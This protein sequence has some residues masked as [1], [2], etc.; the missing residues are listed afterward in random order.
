MDAVDR[1]GDS[2][3]ARD[4]LV[5]RKRRTNLWMCVSDTFINQACQSARNGPQSSSVKRV[6]AHPTVVTKRV[7]P[8][9]VEES[10]RNEGRKTFVELVTTRPPSPTGILR[11]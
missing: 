9:D 1:G 10:T 11:H 3:S 5:E 8:D 2:S 7:L 4:G 6:R